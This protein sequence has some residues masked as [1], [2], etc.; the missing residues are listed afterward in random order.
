MEVEVT[1]EDEM[2]LDLEHLLGHFPEN[3]AHFQL[4]SLRRLHSFEYTK[5]KM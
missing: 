1:G 3:R 4:V 2:V 5:L